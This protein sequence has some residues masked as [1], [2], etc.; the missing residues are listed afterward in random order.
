M[1]IYVNICHLQGYPQT[2][3]KLST[4][5]RLIHNFRKWKSVIALIHRVIHKVWVTNQLYA[6]RNFLKY[7]V[8][9]AW[10]YA[11]NVLVY[12]Y[13]KTQQN[14]ITTEGAKAMIKHNFVLTQHAKERIEQRGI[15]VNQFLSRDLDFRNIRTTI[16]KE[17]LQIR[18]TKNYLRIAI[19]GNKIV[20]VSKVNRQSMMSEVLDSKL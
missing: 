14:N 5:G 6:D 11:M 8:L 7:F 16:V 1:S 18:F 12:K 9:F 15:N 10:L 13:S 3:D 20:T 19:D 4:V 2:R 17:G